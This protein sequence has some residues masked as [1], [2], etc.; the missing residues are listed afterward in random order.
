MELDKAAQVGIRRPQRLLVVE[1]R[2]DVA[3]LLVRAQRREHIVLAFSGSG[4][5]DEGS[6]AIELR[7]N[8]AH[9]LHE[10]ETGREKRRERRMELAG[11]VEVARQARVGEVQVAPVEPRAEFFGKPGLQECG[12]IALELF[13]HGRKDFRPIDVVHDDRLQGSLAN[14][15]EGIRVAARIRR[16]DLDR[17]QEPA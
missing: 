12:R 14:A 5:G 9:P 8:A 16:V 17:A 6:P 13:H 15:I 2:R 3:A 1:M 10:S 4:R 7:E 11:F